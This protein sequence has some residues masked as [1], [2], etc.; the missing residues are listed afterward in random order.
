MTSF[1]T[2]CNSVLIN[3]LRV[4]LKLYSLVSKSFW[5]RTAKPQGLLIDIL[6]ETTGFHVEYQSQSH[7]KSFIASIMQVQYIQVVNMN[8]QKQLWTL[9]NIN[10]VKQIFDSNYS[11]NCPKSRYPMTSQPVQPQGTMLLRRNS[12]L[13]GKQ[14]F[15]IKCLFQLYLLRPEADRNIVRKERQTGDKNKDTQNNRPVTCWALTLPYY[16]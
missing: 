9:W 6:R 15:H 13:L 1:R 10:R 2:L 3:T 14:S 4:R 7:L 12:Q 5:Y 11:N 8:K 16:D